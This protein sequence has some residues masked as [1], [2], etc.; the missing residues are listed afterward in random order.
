LFDPDHLRR[1]LV[2]LLENAARHSTDQPGAMLVQ[3]EALDAPLIRLAVASDGEPIPAEVEAHLF[4][5]FHST[6]SRGTGL[7]LYI[8]RELCERHGASIDYLRRPSERHANLFQVVMRRD[9]V[10]TEGRL[11]L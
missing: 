5:P 6:R 7:G 3:L 8:C 2:N 1:V 11:H 10:A 4:E 9:A